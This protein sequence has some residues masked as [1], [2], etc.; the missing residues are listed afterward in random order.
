MHGWPRKMWKQARPV[1]IGVLCLWLLM[2]A[3]I[4]A[5]DPNDKEK[6][7]ASDEEI[8]S[9]LFLEFLVEF[10]TEDGEWTDPQEL[11]KMAL[12]DSEKNE[13][14]KKQLPNFNKLLG[15]IIDPPHPC[16]RMGCFMG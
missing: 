9:L 3:P 13:D 8:P 15:R 10:E 14:E 6:P 1:L 5:Q 7:E 4:M 12:V 2:V 16:L 11:E